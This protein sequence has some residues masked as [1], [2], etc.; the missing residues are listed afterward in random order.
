MRA[1]TITGS[2]ARRSTTVVN[3]TVGS[4]M[5]AALMAAP[6][7]ASEAPNV[8]GKA[9]TSTASAPSE[10]KDFTWVQTGPVTFYHSLTGADRVYERISEVPALTI[11][12]P[13]VWEIS[14]H[15]RSQ[16]DVANASATGWV[17]T[18]LFS[19]GKLI[20][21][22]EALTGIQGNGPEHQTTVGQTLL[23]KFDA[24]DVVTL[25][26]YRVG[27]A[28]TITISSNFDGRTGITAHLI[29]PAVGTPPQ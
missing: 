24:G 28:K 19:N 21:G 10:P 12:Y 15:A 6:A 2:R 29:S 26:A 4:V 18:A 14:Y 5:L 20:P 7:Y 17:H 25:N 11:P 22:S 3:A 23:H 1:A 9:R 13:G 16:V 8:H 27:Q